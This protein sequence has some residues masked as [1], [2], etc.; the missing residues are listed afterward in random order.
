MHGTQF[1]PRLT[2]LFL[3]MMDEAAADLAAFLADLEGAAAASTYI[4]A[5][6]R[7]SKALAENADGAG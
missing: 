2:D 6:S 4:V 1:D 3:A 7:I 5:E